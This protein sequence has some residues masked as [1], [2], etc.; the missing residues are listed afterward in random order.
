[1]AATKPVV[2]G[3]AIQ[4]TEVVSLRIDGALLGCVRDRARE[5]GRSLSGTIVSLIR[6]QLV[7]APESHTGVLPITGWLAPRTVPSSVAAARSGRRAA[8][9]K[10]LSAVK[11]KA[12]RP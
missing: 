4:E 7:D 6:E 11:R 8:S 12:R 3:H 1:M 2:H 5:E 10:L 9:Q